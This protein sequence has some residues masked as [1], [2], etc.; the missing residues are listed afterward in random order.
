[1]DISSVCV[2]QYELLHHQKQNIM[3]RVL[4]SELNILNNVYNEGLSLHV[5]PA[6]SW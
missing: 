4:F 2:I 5:S 3:E 1:M 6:V